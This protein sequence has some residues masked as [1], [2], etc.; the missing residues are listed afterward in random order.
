MRSN[1]PETKFFEVLNFL[2]QSGNCLRILCHRCYC[3][4]W[5]EST[6]K[7]SS[8]S[9]LHSKT[10]RVSALTTTQRHVVSVRSQQHLTVLTYGEL[11]EEGRR[12]F[13][14]PESVYISTC[15]WL[16]IPAAVTRFVLLIIS[17]QSSRCVATPVH[18]VAPAALFESAHF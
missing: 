10:C 4:V 11:Q 1:L 5:N 8:G 15:V 6:P 2:L 13:S 3:C 7:L 14:G 16:F 12:T 17:A 9:A 18:S